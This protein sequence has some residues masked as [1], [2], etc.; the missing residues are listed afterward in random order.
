[1]SEIQQSQKK[2]NGGFVAVILLLLIGLGAIAYFLSASNKQLDLCKND[3]RMLNA[4]MEGMNQMMSG[5]LGTMS[6]DMKTDF[7][8]MLDTYDALLEKDKTQADSINSHKERILEL[9]DQ[10]KRGKMSAHQLFKARKEI[11]TMKQIMRGYIVQIDSL[12]TLNLTLY[13]RVDS[14]S[15]ALKTT[16][17]ERDQA[18][19]EALQSAEKVKKGSKLQAYSFSSGGLKMK[20]NNSMTPSDRARNVV[21]IQSSF[22]ISEN[23][24]APSG[25]KT[26]YLQI[27]DPDGKILQSSSG[28]FVAMESGQVAFS[29]YKDIDY[30][31][32]RIDVAIYYKLGGIEASKGNYKVNI[33]CQGQL[34]GKDSFTLK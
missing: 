11:E 6:N 18:R 28:N 15:T 12:N 3:N 30:Q 23:P 22:T 5:Y 8:S 17:G 14:T 10:V 26:V 24:I 31:N 16:K 33:F 34:I 9:Q 13:N 21:Q 32:Q 2:G 4:D 1:M 29:D 19:D 27:V 20:L 25:K 7:T